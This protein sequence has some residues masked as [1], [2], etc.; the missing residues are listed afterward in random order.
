M[1]QH[2]SDEPILYDWEVRL[3]ILEHFR[4]Q[5]ILKLPDPRAVFSKIA[6]LQV[7]PDSRGVHLASLYTTGP[8]E[9]AWLYV[10]NT[11]TRKMR[12][13]WTSFDGIDFQGI[14]KKSWELGPDALPEMTRNL[15]RDK[16]DL[17]E[18]LFNLCTSNGKRVKLRK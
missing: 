9:Q 3:F 17:M 6:E 11:D 13:L 15:G 8:L 4:F 12:P 7:V 14:Y 2:E 1:M 18:E 10:G 16:R 5:S